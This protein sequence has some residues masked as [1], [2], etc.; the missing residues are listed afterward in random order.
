MATEKE[1]RLA[2]IIEKLELEWGD[3]RLVGWNASIEFKIQRYFELLNR[4]EFHGGLDSDGNYDTRSDNDI[5]ILGM[6]LFGGGKRNK[7]EELAK[8]GITPQ[9][10]TLLKE[11]TE[12]QN[13]PSGP[14]P[15][16]E[17]RLNQATDPEFAGLEGLGF[18][19]TDREAF[20]QSSLND[21]RIDFGR[22]ASSVRPTS[23]ENF[24]FNWV[25]DHPN[26]DRFSVLEDDPIYREALGAYIQR[27][28]GQNTLESGYLFADVHKPL[29]DQAVLNGF[30]GTFDKWAQGNAE[31]LTEQ[32]QQIDE[33][34]VGISW[35]DA[36]IA[37]Q[38]EKD[39]VT[40]NSALDDQGTDPQDVP[41]VEYD[42]ETGKVK[43]LV[44]KAQWDAFVLD[45]LNSYGS[46]AM[47]YLNDNAEAIQL[48]YSEA[49]ANDDYAGQFVEWGRTFVPE[50]L[51]DL[52]K[53]FDR[54]I[55]DNDP[56]IDPLIFKAYGRLEEK[57]QEFVYNTLKGRL[58]AEMRNNPDIEKKTDVWNSVSEAKRKQ[59]LDLALNGKL[60]GY[61]NIEEVLEF[62]ELNHTTLADLYL[63]SDWK[64]NY[65]SMGETFNS[66]VAGINAGLP[67]EVP[68]LGVADPAEQIFIDEF[69]ELNFKKHAED[70]DSH[71]Y[72]RFMTQMKGRVSSL[73]E[74]K[75]FNPDGINELNMAEALD[76][77][78]NSPE[79][80]PNIILR[81]TILDE[82]SAL[83]NENI[84]EEVLK[85]LNAGASVASV[86]RDYGIGASASAQG[87]ER[88][89]ESQF[90]DFEDGASEDAPIPPELAAIIDPILDGLHDDV[91]DIGLASAFETLDRE[92]NFGGGAST[93]DI[94]AEF[95]EDIRANVERDIMKPFD[96]ATQLFIEHSGGLA[97]FFNDFPTF[98]DLDLAEINDS[99]K[100]VV[101]A[102]P[103]E[104]L[105]G[106][107]A[108][109]VAALAEIQSDPALNLKL[110]DILAPTNEARAEIAEL[111]AE[112]TA[113]EQRRAEVDRQNEQIRLENARNRGLNALDEQSFNKLREFFG[114][115]LTAQ[116]ANLIMQDF[117]ADL[118]AE[119]SAKTLNAS[120]EAGGLASDFS[121]LDAQGN[122]LPDSGEQFQLTDDETAFFG[123]N[124]ID[125]N[126][127]HGKTRNPDFDPDDPDSQEFLPGLSDEQNAD[128]DRRLEEAGKRSSESASARSRA[129]RTSEIGFGNLG[130][131]DSRTLGIL[132]ESQLSR[133]RFR[134]SRSRQRTRANS[135]TALA[136]A[137]TRLQ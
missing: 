34:Y 82:V 73:L 110:E 33:K 65:T 96:D 112:E 111:E 102:D 1:L 14:F 46:V 89:M 15:D 51:E 42:E 119:L 55:R 109:V 9:V 80:N 3:T 124:A 45:M 21:E 23:V 91:R 41:V 66:F 70:L 61:D 122:L 30:R 105:H 123:G 31:D 108:R 84:R 129:T 75:S 29:Y 8:L 19:D 22:P 64:G 81:D 128:L 77:I 37:I 53:E 79:W 134:V 11:Y 116:Q 5:N 120:Q 60:A 72:R 99:I 28:L 27:T 35:W 115:S 13:T 47:E 88:L 26:T 83:K 58:Q 131:N 74:R 117:G 125:N 92:F 44:V 63:S 97:K 85:Q 10:E 17:T 50:R 71:I 62:L 103:A 32:M 43:N 56:I 121:Q 95:E 18:G 130:L 40:R 113:N 12:I 25:M 90:I 93:E 7:R 78:T 107:N 69:V 135:R 67:E 132:R 114:Q 133:R 6:S 106:A 76:I 38:N 136:G 100:K 2:K 52:Q 48:E 104:E 127:R 59:W 4:I 68:N 126:L 118:V 36:S 137:S 98:K 20:V 101:F 54:Q 86:Y 16:T 87:W 39:M 24:V 57:H 49:R 94:I